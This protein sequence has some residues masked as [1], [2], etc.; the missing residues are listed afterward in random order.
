MKQLI[1]AVLAWVCVACTGGVALLAAAEYLVGC[2]EPIY[3]ANGTYTTNEC[4]F[5][6]YTPT[7]GRW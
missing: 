2:G 7:S 5:I 6:P 3:Y 1:T 4:L